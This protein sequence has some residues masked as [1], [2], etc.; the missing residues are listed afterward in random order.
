M[1]ARGSSRLGCPRNGMG[2]PRLMVMGTEVPC[3]SGNRQ[4]GQR[5]HVD[6]ADEGET[7]GKEPNSTARKSR[8]DCQIQLQAEKNMITRQSVLL[9]CNQRHISTQMLYDASH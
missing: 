7:C 3:K 2:M 8:Q 6:D 5:M 1:A 9:H 4:C